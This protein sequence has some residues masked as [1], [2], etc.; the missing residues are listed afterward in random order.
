MTVAQT[1]NSKVVLCTVYDEPSLRTGE[2]LYDEDTDTLY[3]G[4][5]D[6]MGDTYL[7]ITNFLQHRTSIG[8]I[9]AP[10]ITARVE[11]QMPQLSSHTEHLYIP[12]PRLQFSNAVAMPTLASSTSSRK[13]NLLYHDITNLVNSVE[14]VV[15]TEVIHE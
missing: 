4:A 6:V 11:V 9:P 5:G 12:T 10:R 13:T 7:Y 14:T 15:E 2:F 3:V 8:Y 1:E